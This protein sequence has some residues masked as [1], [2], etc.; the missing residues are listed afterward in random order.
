MARSQDRLELEHLLDEL[1]DAFDRSHASHEV[2][3]AA[4]LAFAAKLLQVFADGHG[5]PVLGVTQRL[6]AKLVE[7]TRRYQTRAL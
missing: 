5:V 6:E 1:E 3:A 2:K 4:G 7:Q